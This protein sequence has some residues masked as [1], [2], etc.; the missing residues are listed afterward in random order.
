MSSEQGV[1]ASPTLSAVT[2]C[3]TLGPSLHLLDIS[4]QGSSQHL[5]ELRPPLLLP[6][7]DGRPAVQGAACTVVGPFPT[8]LAC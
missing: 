6:L 1:G 8:C 2:R 3:V 7:G 5:W 4:T